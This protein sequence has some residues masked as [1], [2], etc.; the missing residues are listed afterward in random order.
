MIKNM[1]FLQIRGSGSIKI[2]IS[3]SKSPCMQY[4]SFVAAWSV[5][6][7]QKASKNVYNQ[8]SLTIV[9]NH[10]KASKIVHNQL[11]SFKHHV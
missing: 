8:K 3:M 4:M 5:E 10:I 9:Y 7:R 11:K 2:E 6:L 1:S